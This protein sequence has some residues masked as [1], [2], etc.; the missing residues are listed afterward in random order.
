V[1]HRFIFGVLYQGVGLVDFLLKPF[2]LLSDGG[3]AHF[4]AL[5][6]VDIFLDLSWVYRLITLE[7]VLVYI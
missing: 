5:R 3:L 4:S 7:M 6:T 2:D 1:A